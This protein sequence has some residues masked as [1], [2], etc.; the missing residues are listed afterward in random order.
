MAQIA[1]YLRLNDEEN[2]RRLLEESYES[3]LQEYEKVIGDES[4]HII[5][6]AIHARIEAVRTY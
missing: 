4:A 5:A 2:A 6:N 3:Q 1:K